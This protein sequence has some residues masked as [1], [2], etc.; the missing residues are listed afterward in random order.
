MVFL[1]NTEVNAET[2]DFLCS[3]MHKMSHKI[4]YWPLVVYNI[5]NCWAVIYSN[6]HTCSGVSSVFKCGSK[7]HKLIF[8]KVA[9][10]YRH[11]RVTFLSFLFYG[12]IGYSG[13]LCAESSGLFWACLSNPV[14]LV[15]SEI[16]QRSLQLQWKQRDLPK[17]VFFHIDLKLFCM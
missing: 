6:G 5:I 13:L 17:C 3:Y 16:W 14:A 4:V 12:T 15:C 7:Y 8:C 9:C 1:K 11:M 10:K 2:S